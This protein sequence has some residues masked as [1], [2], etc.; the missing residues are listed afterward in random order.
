[1]NT[2]LSGSGNL[3]HLKYKTKEDKTTGLEFLLARRTDRDLLSLQSPTRS[4]QNLPNPLFLFGSGVPNLHSVADLKS[5]GHKSVRHTL[6][7]F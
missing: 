7:I 5:G 1:M 2:S 4:E 6:K 3:K